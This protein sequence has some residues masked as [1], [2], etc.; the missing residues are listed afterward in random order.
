MPSRVCKSFVSIR[1]EV[2][3]RGWAYKSVSWNGMGIQ[4]SFL[5]RDKHTNPFLGLGW[6]T[7]KLCGMGWA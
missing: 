2:L 7:N 4:T 6:P 3:E 5:Q 1:L